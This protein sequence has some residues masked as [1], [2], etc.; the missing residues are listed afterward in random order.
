MV[1]A[2]ENHCLG[3]QEEWYTSTKEKKIEITVALEQASNNK[4]E[5]AALWSVLRIAL[6]K[7]LNNM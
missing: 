3:V 1:L 7:Q 2:K 5:L 6:D 4:V